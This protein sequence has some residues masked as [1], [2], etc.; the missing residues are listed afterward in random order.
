MCLPIL[1]ENQQFLWRRKKEKEGLWEGLP[2]LFCEYIT[3]V[4]GTKENMTKMEAEKQNQ[5]YVILLRCFSAL[6][7]FLGFFL[8]LFFLKQ[9]EVLFLEKK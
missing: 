1:S 4:Y 2:F 3:A 5:L 8:K 7:A 6:C 9:E